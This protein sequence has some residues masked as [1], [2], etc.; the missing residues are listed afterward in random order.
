MLF[1]AISLYRQIAEK[2]GKAVCFI[3]AIIKYT[4]A[5]HPKRGLSHFALFPLFCSHGSSSNS[6]ASTSSFFSCW[7]HFLWRERLANDAAEVKELWLI[8]ALLG[9]RQVSFLTL[10]SS[11]RCGGFFTRPPSPL[12]LPPHTHPVAFYL[13]L[14]IRASL[15]PQSPA[16]LL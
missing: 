15:I 8:A 10:W 12:N 11:S 3:R 4:P 13:K 6:L 7:L 9:W 5:V 2:F 16:A 1:S 14:I